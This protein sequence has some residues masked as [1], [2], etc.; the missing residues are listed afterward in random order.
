M[1]SD[2]PSGKSIEGSLRNKIH[3][4]I[5]IYNRRANVG[6]RRRIAKKRKHEETPTCEHALQ[7][8]DKTSLLQQ[9]EQV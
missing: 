5:C 8:H 7:S 6:L 1:I 4:C 3:I 9:T 2:M